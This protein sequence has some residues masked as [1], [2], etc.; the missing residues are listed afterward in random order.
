MD[1]MEKKEQLNETEAAPEP[2]NQ[3]E[4]AAPEAAG[5]A[6]KPV[7]EAATPT[8]SGGVDI[9]AKES[10]SFTSVPLQGGAA[11]A[12]AL[13]EAALPD[14]FED[15]SAE[16]KDED[17][18]AIDGKQ[19]VL[20]EQKSADGQ[21]TMQL[22]AQAPAKPAASQAKPGPWGAIVKPIIVL[23]AVCLI[24]SFLLGI[25]N[26]LTE[27]VIAE[28]TAK[29]DNAA[30]ALLL[31]EADSFEEQPVPEN[32]GNV[33]SIHRATN[34]SGWVIGAF[35][36]GYGGKVP[37]L[38]AFDTDGNIAGAAFTENSETVGLGQKVRDEEFSSQ[39]ASRPAQPMAL[40]DIDAIASATISSGAAVNAVNYAVEAYQQETGGAARPTGPDEVNTSLL[41][42]ESL[43]PI[44]ISGANVQPT[45]YKSDA[46][47]YIIYGEVPGGQ[48]GTKLLVAAVAMDE[49]GTV[50]NLWLDTSSES[51]AY[52]GL[53]ATDQAYLNSF[54]G[55]TSPVQVDTVAD[56]TNSSSRVND[57]VDAALNALPAAKE[58]A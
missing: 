4:T 30:R 27:P 41:P 11:H 37:V 53:L 22:A 56:V 5:A 51:E 36:Q 50:L 1:E 42:G 15:E 47:N 52:G 43:A 3:P 8:P 33:T 21:T 10:A 55:Q 38:V 6:E 19:A 25:T 39:F 44:T 18:I 46:G 28:N 48:D 7:A 54:V 12:E 20:V 31:P 9:D 29:A 16:A 17:Y 13:T 24:T 58:A 2:V 32:L 45:A 34:G 35:A 26:Q 14:V 23:V 49:S 40:S 57:A